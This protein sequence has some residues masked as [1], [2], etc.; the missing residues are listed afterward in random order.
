MQSSKQDRPKRKRIDTTDRPVADTSIGKEE[1]VV[2]GKV[3]YEKVGMATK[4][5]NSSMFYL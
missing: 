5:E 2:V 1:K 4:N 3:V